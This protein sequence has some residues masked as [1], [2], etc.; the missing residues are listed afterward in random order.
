MQYDYNGT[1]IEL[2]DRV[3]QYWDTTPGEINPQ[4]NLYIR[5][6]NICNAHCKFCEYHGDKKEFSI[7]R[8]N[9]VLDDLAKRGI[10]GKI[11]ITGGEPSTLGDKLRDIARATRDR[12]ENRF[13]GVNSNGYSLSTLESISGIVD[14]YAI[15]RHHYNDAKNREIFGTTKVPN[16]YELEGFIAAVGTGKVH[17]SC[18][19]MKNGIGTLD[20]IK[21]YLDWVSSIGCNDVGFVT[22]MNANQFCKDNQVIFDTCGIDDS[23]EF[24]EYARFVKSG[25]ACRCSNYLYFC[26]TT[27]KMV[28]IYGRFV[29]D[30]K[31]STG[32]ISFDGVNLRSGFSGDIINI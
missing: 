13:I 18:N 9:K 21:K 27:C 15:S 5:A 2:K 7:D 19:L 32:L 29:L 28:D 20:E 22:L 17:F 31:A 10:I 25:N 23:I 14:N 3:C 6:T 30:T 8:L 11:Q 4:V 26:K 12:F 24:T 16:E 1:I